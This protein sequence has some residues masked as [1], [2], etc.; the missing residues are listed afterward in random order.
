MS[1]ILF[2]IISLYQ[3]SINGLIPMPVKVVYLLSSYRYHATTFQN[4]D[5]LPNCVLY[6]DLF[7]I[8]HST[9][10]YVYINNKSECCLMEELQTKCHVFWFVG[11]LW[12]LDCWWCFTNQNLIFW[13]S[14]SVRIMKE[15]FIITPL[16]FQRMSYYLYQSLPTL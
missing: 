4:S 13:T 10:N 7:L 3:L 8:C 16:L 11:L 12:L 1:N 9:V 2:T 6:S 15:L 5:L 14:T